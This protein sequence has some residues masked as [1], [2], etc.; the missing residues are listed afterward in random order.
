MGNSQSEALAKNLSPQQ[1]QAWKSLVI[2]NQ[3]IKEDF[4]VICRENEALKQKHSELLNENVVANLERNSAALEVK[5]VQTEISLMKSPG[6]E[7]RKVRMFDDKSCNTDKAADEG[8]SDPLGVVR[9]ASTFTEVPSNVSVQE[10][11][12][13]RELLNEK[14]QEVRVLEM[15]LQQTKQEFELHK[16]NSKKVK[17][18]HKATIALRN[19]EVKKK[20]TEIDQ[21]KQDLA[22]AWKCHKME[23]EGS[24]KL[25]DRLINECLLSGSRQAQIEEL[26]KQIAAMTESAK[27]KTKLA[28]QLSKKGNEIAAL[29][30]E[31]QTK[32]KQIEKQ[33][34]AL[35]SLQCENNKLKTSFNSLQDSQKEHT[36]KNQAALEKALNADEVD[37]VSVHLVAEVYKLYKEKADLLEKCLDSQSSSKTS[38]SESTQNLKPQLTSLEPVQ[39]DSNTTPTVSAKTTCEV[40]HST[41]INSESTK[42]VRL[43]CLYEK[44]SDE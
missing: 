18:S 38:T 14:N 41:C 19:A 43:F 33:A 42:I 29:K 9:S 4:D 2:E 11:T 39:K 8:H 6:F 20:N 7:L 30:K 31:V 25:N 37:V 15:S 5:S 16:E 26:Q 36:R 35:T 21:L 28:N 24:K 22:H 13:L 23:A 3:R 32:K 44:L 10:F 12:E 17:S 40:L 1:I 27:S 34:A